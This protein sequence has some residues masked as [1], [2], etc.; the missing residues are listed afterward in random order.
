MPNESRCESAVF[1]ESSSAATRGALHACGRTGCAYA[2]AL[3]WNDHRGNST[4]R[5]VAVSFTRMLGRAHSRT[6]RDHAARHW[7]N[8]DSESR[9][10]VHRR[11]SGR[12]G[13]H[14]RIVCK[15]DDAD[16]VGTCRIPDG[17]KCDHVPLAH[18]ISP[19]RRMIM[20]ELGLSLRHILWKSW[21][22]RNELAEE[23]FHGV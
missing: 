8:L 6:R 23:C 9:T 3:S 18:P 2:A 10:L 1:M 21:T 17:P 16:P 14:R 15:L 5:A 13:A 7:V 22:R 20:H 4:Q 12:K 19:I 11:I